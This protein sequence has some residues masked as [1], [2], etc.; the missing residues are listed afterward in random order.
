M[1]GNH[2]KLGNKFVLRYYTTLH[3][4]PETLHQ[5]YKE[6]S[7]FTHGYEDGSE[8]TVV[9]QAKINQKILSLDYRDCLVKLAIVDCQESLDGGILVV[10]KGDLSKKGESPKKFLQT[11]FLAVQTE[12]QPGYYVLNDI[13]RYIKDGQ[14]A[15][16]SSTSTETTS[17]GE[18]VALA[19]P[20]KVQE[21]PSQPT[22]KADEPF[23]NGTSNAGHQVH[24]QTTAAP[25]ASETAPEKTPQQN[26]PAAQPV[27]KT[28]P[29]KVETTTKQEPKQQGTKDAVNGKEK[30]SARDR[31]T[32]KGPQKSDNKNVN[33]EANNDTTSAPI[34]KVNKPTSWASIVG[35]KGTDHAEPAAT[36]S[37]QQSNAHPPAQPSVQPT[38][39]TQQIPQQ[40]N[41]PQ[42]QQQNQPQK[43]KVNRDFPGL[44]V[45]NIPF[46]STESQIKAV[47][48][49]WGEIKSM[50]VKSKGF[51][52]IEY[53]D[54]I[55]VVRA[56][57]DAKASPI[58]L[59]GR[60]LV[61]EE[62]KQRS[63]PNKPQNQNNDKN[64]EGEFRTPK[65]TNTWKSNK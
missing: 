27:E 38:Q 43:Q 36:H 14:P 16:E 64:A 45:S 19:A 63:A 41:S 49:K 5:F 39:Q 26:S 15:K 37:P 8:E 54:P 56:I 60:T 33:S 13:F 25:V 48:L 31:K 32:S 52:F 20:A 3:D 21:A 6:K 65:K 35:H 57:Q 30:H 46:S 9:G 51:C 50:D 23:V 42:T 7:V 34:Q 29:T 44:Y 18:V 24:P 40:Q 53:V 28:P 11:F 22:R 62:R 47:F 10:V 2:V 1:S 58:V 17:V 61:V 55:N 4:N 59:E 12:P